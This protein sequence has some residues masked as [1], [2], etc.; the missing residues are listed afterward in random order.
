MGILSS[1]CLTYDP[2]IWLKVTSL[3]STASVFRDGKISLK[4]QKSTKKYFFLKTSQ[5][6]DLPVR[7]DFMNLSGFKKYIGLNDLNS[8]F[9][10]KKSKTAYS[11]HTEW[12]SW[13]QKLMG[14]NDLNCISGLNA[15]FHQ[16]KLRAW[17]F[18]Q[19]WHQN[20]ISCSLNVGWS[21]SEFP[22]QLETKFTLHI[23]ICQSKL[24]HKCLPLDAL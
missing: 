17:C 23:S 13:H 5:W 12:F 8:L 11:V 10:L 22:N 18:H 2:L 1:G 16:K 24:K 6:D 15:S 3:S 9:G 20:E 21:Y 19:I 14:L 7:F 4:F